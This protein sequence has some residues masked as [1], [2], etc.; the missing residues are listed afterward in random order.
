MVLKGTQIIPRVPLQ[1]GTQLMYKQASKKH[2]DTLC[3]AKIPYSI[4]RTGLWRAQALRRARHINLSSLAQ[5]CTI[6]VAIR[7]TAKLTY[8]PN[9]V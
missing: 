5:G 1:F 7:P 9:V 2:V 4:W 3:R 6:A 8:T